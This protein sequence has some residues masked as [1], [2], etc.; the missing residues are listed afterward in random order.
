M[1]NHIPIESRTSITVGENF[2]TVDNIVYTQYDPNFKYL[3]GTYI[4]Y[5][6]V[7]YKVLR[8]SLGVVPSAGSNFEEVQAYDNL[9]RTI[10]VDY[11][12]ES[13]LSGS[14]S[15]EGVV[16]GDYITSSDL[17]NTLAGYVTSSSLN[18]TL[19]DYATQSYV[20]SVVS[21]VDHSGYVTNSGLND[22][23][24]NYV[25]SS[26]LSSTLSGYVTSSDLSNYVTSSSLTSTLGSYVTTSNLTST[27]GSYVTSSSLSSTLSSYATNTSV[28]TLSNQIAEME[29]TLDE[30]AKLATSA[31][32]LVL[33]LQQGIAT[34]QEF[35]EDLHGPIT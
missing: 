6:N 24:S 27:L 26:D 9:N 25:T 17:T 30:A 34:I 22:T 32:E 31:H 11:Y 19:T 12:N 2:Y 29:T 10:T 28:T 13:G 20:D 1:E 33:T 21:G 14:S 8:N 7:L 15:S 16:S 18:S 23:L 5:N 4:I 3:T 35:I